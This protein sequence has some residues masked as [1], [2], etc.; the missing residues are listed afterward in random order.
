VVLYLISLIPYVAAG[1][2]NTAIDLGFAIGSLVLTWVLSNLVRRRPP[3]ARIVR[4]GIIELALFVLVPSLLTMSTDA[5]G[6]EEEFGVDAATLGFGLWDYSWQVFLWTA[7]IQLILLV[8]VWLLVELGIW[9][10]ISWLTRE[11]VRGFER[12]G[13]TI[14][15]TV[16]MLIGVVTFFSFTAEVWQS[17]GPLST[18]GYLLIILLFTVVSGVFLGGRWHFDLDA[19]TRFE[20]RAELDHAL[21][22]AELRAHTDDIAL[23]ARAPLGRLQRF[24]LRLIVAL[25]RLVVASWVAGS[26]FVFFT[27]LLVLAVDATVVKA[28]TQTDPSIIW[29]WSSGYRVFALT[30]E[31]L[32]VAGF[33]AVFSGFYFSVVSATDPQLRDELQDTAADAVRQACAARLALAHAYVDTA[34]GSGNPGLPPGSPQDQRDPHDEGRDEPD[35][36]PPTA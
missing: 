27:V 24:N 11:L 28:W 14:A 31:H 19:A 3:F 34:P 22:L 8:M 21:E 20:T 1:P 17:L 4:L 30:H 25:S 32:K 23:P 2:W 16:P 9:T 5:V 29:Q 35:T 18:G 6:M 36:H 13:T 12:T 15:R 7:S 10:L 26:V 33:L